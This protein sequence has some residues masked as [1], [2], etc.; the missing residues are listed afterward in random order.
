MKNYE[1]RRTDRALTEE[2]A[3]EILR[4]GSFGILSTIG[5]D[6]YPYGVPVNYVYDDGRI[7]FHCAKNNGHKQENLRFSGR[8]SFTVVTKSEV[9][10]EKFTT[11][12]E[13][14]VAFGTAS[15]IVFDKEKALRLLV[16][17]YSPQFIDEGESCI[18]DDFEHTDVFM[19]EI[20][21]LTAKANRK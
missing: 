8:V 12:Y 20:E 7:Y 15:K 14:A 2:D 13:S 4:K 3:V 21:R 10:S 9:I 19:L 16:K 5:A 17:K 11:A 6:G 18:K 1:I